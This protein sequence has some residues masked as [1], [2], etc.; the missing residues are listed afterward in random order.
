MAGTTVSFR[1]W[2]VAP[3]PPPL[4]S[5]LVALEPIT[6]TFPLPITPPVLVV[7][8]P[9]E[10]L[11]VGWGT[12]GNALRGVPGGAR[13]ITAAPRNAMEGVPYRLVSIPNGMRSKFAWDVREGRPVLRRWHPPRQRGDRFPPNC[14]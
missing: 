4:T 7:T 10:R 2:P 8:R 13:D 9:L 1:Y 6:S 14:R 11:T 5:I 12:V 3:V